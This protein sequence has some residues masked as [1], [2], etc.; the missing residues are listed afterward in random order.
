MSRKKSSNRLGEIIQ[1]YL[2]V[3]DRNLRA[4]AEEIGISAATL[5]RISHGRTPDADTF[6]K[7]LAWMLTANDI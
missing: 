2:A 4:V 7:L 3:K 5:M 6:T 1:I